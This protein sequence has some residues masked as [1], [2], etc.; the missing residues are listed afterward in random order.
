MIE[1]LAERN[2]Q[3]ETQYLI[4][5]TKFVIL[6]ILTLGLYEFWWVYKAWRFFQEKENSGI[7]APLRTILSI[8]FLMSLFSKINSYA[9]DKG[10][11]KKFYAGVV[12]VNYLLVSLSGFLPF[13]FLILANFSVFMLITPFKA[14]NFAKRHSK[15]VAK[16]R[17]YLFFI[18][19]D[20]LFD[21]SSL[22]L[23]FH[24]KY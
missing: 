7:N 9:L 17:H 5:T 24:R 6:S 1:Q 16:V 13:P 14:L 15:T 18:F 8:V 19:F 4:S 12:F 21:F 3:I 23:V 11:P 2:D 10:N 20:F 22:F